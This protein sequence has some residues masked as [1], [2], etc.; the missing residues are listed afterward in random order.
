MDLQ[1][2]PPTATQIG[3]EEEQCEIPCTRLFEDD[4][5]EYIDTRLNSPIPVMSAIVVQVQG[6]PFKTP[7]KVASKDNIAPNAPK[8]K[9]QNRK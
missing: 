1:L 5:Q 6:D 7:P 3:Q 9:K 4:E 8:K 2:T